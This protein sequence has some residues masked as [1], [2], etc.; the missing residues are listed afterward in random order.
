MRTA[1]DRLWIALDGPRLTSEDDE[2]LREVEPGG[3]VLFRRN[4]ESAEQVRALVEAL[5]NR[6]GAGLHVVVDQEGGAVTRFERECTVFPGNLTLGALAANDRSEALALARQWGRVSGR[7]LA[8][9]GIDGNL[10]PVLDL[11]VRSDNPGIGC[12]SFGADPALVGELAVELA[13]GHHEEGV[14]TVA[15]HFPG[16]GAADLDTHHALP[17]IPPG[18]ESRHLEPFAVAIAGGIPAVMTAHLI[19]EGLDPDAPATASRTVVDEVLRGRL[20]FAGVAMTDALEMGAVGEHPIEARVEAAVRAGHDVLCLCHGREAMLRARRH[21]DAIGAGEDAMVSARLAELPRLRGAGGPI[22]GAA[23]AT[24]IAEG[25]VTLLRQGA[26]PIPIP[27]G[28]RWLLILP[29]PRGLTPAED[30]LRAED[31]LPFAELLGERVECLL[32]SSEPTSEELARAATR[33]IER[34]GILL[35]TLGLP[36]SEARRQLLLSAVEWNPRLCVI[37]LG[38]PGE[39]ARL[40][41]QDFTVLTAYGYRRPHQEALA[42]VLR[43]E[44]VPSGRWPAPPQVRGELG[45]GP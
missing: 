3:I 18:D 2:L 33:S 45:L 20:G 28:E 44:L 5:R 41:R 21:L 42:R 14:F 36:E 22:D 13:A 23:V 43:G 26:A 35:A 38:D 31:L 30:P 17:R 7:E 16:L 24:R 9:L 12:R 11:T 10:A 6:L 39:L 8:S 37:H 32:V 27:P 15:K 34:D 4:I 1:G 19:H 40:P 25:G 29:A